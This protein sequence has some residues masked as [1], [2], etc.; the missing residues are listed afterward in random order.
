ML[1][2]KWHWH[3][4]KLHH[5]NECKPEVTFWENILTIFAMEVI[6]DYHGYG[7]FLS[8]KSTMKLGKLILGYK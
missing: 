3:F 2:S 8:S 4:L 6:Q 5:L 7:S 1:V